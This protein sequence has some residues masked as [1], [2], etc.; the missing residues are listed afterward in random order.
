MQANRVSDPVDLVT[1]ES[2]AIVDTSRISK[3]QQ[4]GEPERL[5]SP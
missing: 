2:K 1:P 3:M 5:F 4:K